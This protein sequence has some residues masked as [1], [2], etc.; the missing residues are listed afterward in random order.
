MTMSTRTTHSA[1]QLAEAFRNGRTITEGDTTR[2]MTADEISTARRFI[3][4]TP[5]RRAWQAAQALA[6]SNTG[7]A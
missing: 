6:A 1:K 5:K 3:R 4:R 2:P 7:G